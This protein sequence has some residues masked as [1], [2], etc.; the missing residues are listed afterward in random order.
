MQGRSWCGEWEG[1]GV[2]KTGFGLYGPGM[3]TFLKIAMFLAAGYAA[4]LGWVY[5]SQRRLLYQPSAVVEATPEVVGLG[6]ADVW[7]TNRLGTRLHGWWVPCAGSR[8]TLLFCHGNGGN[9]SH[10]LESLRLFHELGLSVLVFDYSGYGRSEGTPSEKDTRADARA[11]WDWLV[12]EAGA[13]ASGIVLFGRSLGGAV[14]AG[15]GA[16]LAAGGVQPAGII[17][18][19]TFTSVADMG[20][21]I[22]PWLPVRRLVRDRYDSVAALAGVR[23]PAL[24]GHSP[25]D[26]MVPFELGR[27]LYESYGGPKTFMAMRGG[28]NRGY[29][30]MGPAYAEAFGRFLRT[31]EPRP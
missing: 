8:L 23:L 19:S 4:V 27:A 25:D 26:E 2:H 10:R 20:A 11:G 5:V 14:A 13:E 30:D 17:L 6:Y 1:L 21:R 24:F 16:E 31:V 22:Y 9:V 29:M 18:E 3:W 15:L 7:L 28:H 12:S